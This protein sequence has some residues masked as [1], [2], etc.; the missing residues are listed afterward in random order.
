[1]EIDEF[2]NSIINE[3]VTLEIE[4]E[5]E[6]E[7]YNFD[8]GDIVPIVITAF[9]SVFAK[10]LFEQVKKGILELIVKKKKETEDGTDLSFEIQND[11][12]KISFNI[13]TDL[14]EDKNLRLLDKSKEIYNR[15]EKENWHNNEDITYDHKKIPE[16][17]LFPDDTKKEW[18]PFSKSE[19]QRLYDKMLN[20]LDNLPN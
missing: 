11:K 3:N 7:F 4:K 8:G 19:Q 16:V 15:A 18:K 17:Y 20:Q 12:T 6:P 13:S 1:M 2:K 5:P 9:T 14:K 10:D